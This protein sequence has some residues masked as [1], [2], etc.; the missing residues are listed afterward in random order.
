[1]PRSRTRKILLCYPTL[2]LS[3][4][5]CVPAPNVNTANSFRLSFVY[6]LFIF[7]TSLSTD[8][9]AQSWNDKINLATDS[10]NTNQVQI[11]N[12]KRL[13]PELEN[14]P[15]QDTIGFVYYFM[16]WRYTY[17]NHT[18]DALKA[19]TTSIKQFIESGYSGYRLPYMYKV[20]ADH[21][22]ALGKD[23]LAIADAESIA[24]LT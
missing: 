14:T 6:L 4:W 8:V 11:E 24:S 22:K 1:M 21:Y 10:Q 23:E 17:L 9:S 15:Y 20:R 7:F 3:I 16:A 13:L 18:E 19:A 5:I 2:D 12:L